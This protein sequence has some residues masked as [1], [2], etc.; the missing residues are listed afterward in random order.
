MGM[1]HEANARLPFRNI[2]RAANPRQ[3]TERTDR[4]DRNIQ[5]T[6]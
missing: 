6:G 1:L 4:R 3:T 5:H 2:S